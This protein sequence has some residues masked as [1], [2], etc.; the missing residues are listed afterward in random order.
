MKC[1]NEALGLM[2]RPVAFPSLPLLSSFLTLIHWAGHR[3]FFY[4]AVLHLSAAAVKTREIKSTWLSFYKVCTHCLGR[5]WLYIRSCP[6]NPMRLMNW[7]K[8][9]CSLGRGHCLSLNERHLVYE[10]WHANGLP[11]SPNHFTD[12]LSILAIQF[13]LRAG[14]HFIQVNWASFVLMTWI[15]EK[16]QN[17]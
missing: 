2:Y 15:L 17:I 8:C 16:F 14:Y 4:P 9:H 5:T 11:C 6:P 12:S 3:I 7:R 1:V 13:H 10:G